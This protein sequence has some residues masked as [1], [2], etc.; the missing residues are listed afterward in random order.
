MCKGPQ[1]DSNLTLQI[2]RYAMALTAFR[3]LIQYRLWMRVGVARKARR[4]GLMFILVAKDTG[5]IMVLG[6]VLC[7]QVEGLL[8]TRPAIMRR[9]LLGICHDQWHVNRMARHAGIKIHVFG[10]LFV[11]LGTVGDLPV[12]RVT[13]ATR[14]IRVGAGVF[15]HLVALLGMT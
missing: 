12:D 9:G 6:R 2:M 5:K 10:V 11:T 4:Y 15:L 1:I 7:K 8:M 3:K 14:Y 13:F